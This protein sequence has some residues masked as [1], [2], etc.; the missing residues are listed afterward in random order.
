MTPMEVATA[1]MAEL[2]EGLK[3]AGLSQNAAIRF[4]ATVFV[5]QSDPD[6]DAEPDG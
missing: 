2:I 4:A 5:L 1:Q 6:E 3:K